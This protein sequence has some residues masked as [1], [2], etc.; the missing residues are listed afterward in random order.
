MKQRF[1]DFYL[2][3]AKECSQ[4]SYGQRLKVGAVLVKDD[5]ILSFSWNGTPSGWDN[6]CED[7]V[8]DSSAGGWLTPVELDAQYPFSAYHPEAQ[9]EVRYGLRTKDEVIHAEENVI[10]KAAKYGGVGTKGSTMFITHSPCVKCARGMIQAGIAAVYYSEDYR[11]ADGVDF[12]RK[13]GIEV[14]KV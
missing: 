13:G 14:I 2:R 1:I 3:I 10:A 5:N 11:S 8:W 6:T 7:K 12:L 9:R 4:M